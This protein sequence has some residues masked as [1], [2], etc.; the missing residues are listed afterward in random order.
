[1]SGIEEV[2]KKST[3]GKIVSSDKVKYEGLNTTLG[4][5]DVMKVENTGNAYNDFLDT[6]PNASQFQK[7]M[8]QNLLGG[9]GSSSPGRAHTK[10]G[11]MPVKPSVISRRMQTYFAGLDEKDS[12]FVNE[13]FVEYNAGTSIK[14]LDVDDVLLNLS[15]G[16][17]MPPTIPGPNPRRPPAKTLYGRK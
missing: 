17:P 3:G 10:Y 4:S 1:M 2:L 15:G 11:V 13:K 14:V 12:F 6:Y 8:A 5:V 7:Q 16:S 9:S